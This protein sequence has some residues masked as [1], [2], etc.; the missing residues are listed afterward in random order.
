[1]VSPSAAI[2]DPVLAAI[3][4]LDIAIAPITRKIDGVGLNDQQ[5]EQLA[6][7]AG[8]L[9]KTRLDEIVNQASFAHLAEASQRDMITKS[10]SATRKHARALILAGNHEIKEAA[11]KAKAAYRE[12]ASKKQVREMLKEPAR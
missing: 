12:G 5:Y 2:D 11:D 7:A 3:E 4:R 6:T 8:R 10:I 9:T 1:M